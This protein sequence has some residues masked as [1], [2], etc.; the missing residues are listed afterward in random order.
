MLLGPWSERCLLLRDAVLHVLSFCCPPPVSSGVPDV[1]DVDLDTEGKWDL[2]DVL[3]LGEVDARPNLRTDFT[4]FRDKGID[5][6][7][8]APTTAAG[9]LKL[10]LLGLN[11]IGKQRELL[12][13]A[14]QLHS[15]ILSSAAQRRRF[16]IKYRGILQS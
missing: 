6:S 8:E 16:S 7:I 2:S 15:T 9:V 5:Y 12:A 13:I 10:G 11:T 14:D 3:H 1:H 4:L